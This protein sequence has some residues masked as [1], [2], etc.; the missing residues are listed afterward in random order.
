MV[1][2]SVFRVK[3]SRSSA[4]RR[5]LASTSSAA[6]GFLGLLTKLSAGSDRLQQARRRAR[7]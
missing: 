5:S 2:T 7:A 4:K 6:S 3:R 1:R